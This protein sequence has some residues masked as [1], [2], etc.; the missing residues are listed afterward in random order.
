[1]M[2]G[3]LLTT[4]LLGWSIFSGYVKLRGGMIHT[5]SNM[6]TKI[7]RKKPR[8]FLM[9]QLKFQG[10][11]NLGSFSEAIFFLQIQSFLLPAVWGL[12]ILVGNWYGNSEVKLSDYYP[13]L[14]L[15]NFPVQIADWLHR[16][17]YQPSFF[18]T[19]IDKCDCQIKPNWKKRVKCQ[20]LSGTSLSVLLELRTASPHFS[21]RN[22]GL[23][24]P[25][26]SHMK[27]E[28]TWRNPISLFIVQ[29]SFIFRDLYPSLHQVSWLH[30]FEV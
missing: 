2:L 10:A 26:I 18:K 23:R 19:Q 28:E 15:F 7:Y 3:R 13:F 21:G 17:K 24:Y 9:N 29:L 25:T 11:K 5:S 8:G 1:M 20:A 22:A 6:P 4:F 14:K 12:G 16:K 27:G 30:H